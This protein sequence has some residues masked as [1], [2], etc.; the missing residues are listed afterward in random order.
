LALAEPQGY[1]R[2]FIDEGQPMVELL[3]FAL[4][5]NI[6]PVYASKLLTAFPEDG[7]SIVRI[8]KG[9]TANVQLLDEPLSER[10]IE[11]LRLIADGYKYKE[12]AQRLVVSINTVRHHT[13]NVY[14]KLDVNNRTKAIGRAKE[15][16][17]L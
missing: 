2:L 13:R 4:S 10:E 6:A 8:E 1:V 9:S 14:G 7:M 16:N 12:I 15:L 11:V 17:L 3:R 5:H